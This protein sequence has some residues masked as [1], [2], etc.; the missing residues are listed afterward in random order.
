ME[1]SSGPPT[2][3]LCT[4][5]VPKSETQNDVLVCCS[6]NEFVEDVEGAL[7]RNFNEKRVNALSN[8]FKD[9]GTFQKVGKDVLHN[10]INGYS[11]KGKDRLELIDA[12]DTAQWSIFIQD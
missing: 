3:T 4:Y 6:I 9:L 1:P 2:T 8:V 11:I 10:V 5:S 7:E 12:Q